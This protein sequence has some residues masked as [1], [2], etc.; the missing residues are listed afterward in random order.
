MFHARGVVAGAFPHGDDC[1]NQPER[2][3][4]RGCG[5]ATRA[6]KPRGSLVRRPRMSNSPSYAH[7][8]IAT[9]LAGMVAL[10]SACG[11]N[12][13]SNDGARPEKTGRP[14]R[15][16]YLAY[17]SGKKFELV[18]ESHSDRNELYSSAR[19]LDEA[20][21]KVA[22]DEVLDETIAFFRENGFFQRSSP[23]SAPL[24]AGAGVSQALE[25]E[26]SGRTTFWPLMRTASADDQKRFQT[27]S[28]NFLKL[29][30][31][32][33]GLQ[34]VKRAPDWQNQG[35]TTKKKKGQ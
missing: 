35:V 20:F 7:F 3:R 2:A 6:L 34:S 24:T 22:P 27:C 5:A 32:T 21:T 29:Y 18:N 12:P 19:D 26:E 13:S 1:A 23:G 30:T 14:L 4:V 10:F 33:Y 31:N 25:V 16:R 8:V 28:T 17:A 15:V 9:C 11:S